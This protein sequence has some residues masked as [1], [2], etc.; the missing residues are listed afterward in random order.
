MILRVLPG[1]ILCIAA[2]C[3]MAD[4]RPASHAPV[5]SAAS[6]SHAGIQVQTGRQAGAS[7]G[8]KPLQLQVSPRKRDASPGPAPTPDFNPLKRRRMAMPVTPDSDLAF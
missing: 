5:A 8:F 2:T 3:A 6:A 4:A 7:Q 1:A